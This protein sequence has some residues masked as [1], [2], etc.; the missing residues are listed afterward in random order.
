M[1]VLRGR[2]GEG[3]WSRGNTD[4]KVIIVYLKL[5]GHD[6]WMKKMFFDTV[7]ISLSSVTKGCRKNIF[8]RAHTQTHKHTNKQ[9]HTQ[10]THTHARTHARARA[11]YYT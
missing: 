2:D 8:M 5:A 10:H 3:D 9:T 7:T 11:R 4:T 1:E 6:G